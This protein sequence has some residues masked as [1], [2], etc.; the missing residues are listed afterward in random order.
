MTS[1]CS[2][3]TAST[4]A[5]AGGGVFTI[6][7]H[8]PPPPQYCS[9]SCNDLS[10][11]QHALEHS[12]AAQQGLT[13][14][15]SIQH[16]NPALPQAPHGPPADQ[17]TLPRS[18][19]LQHCLQRSASVERSIPRPIVRQHSGLS[20]SPPPIT[21][22]HGTPVTFALHHPARGH[23]GVIYSSSVEANLNEQGMHASHGSSATAAHPASIHYVQPHPG[24]AGDVPM[25]I[26]S[27]HGAPMQG[28]NT[29]QVHMSLGLAPSHLLGVSPAAHARMGTNTMT[30]SGGA[31]GVGEPPITHSSPKSRAKHVTWSGGQ[32]HGEESAV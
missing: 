20:R 21:T 31:E 16:M 29:G 22:H 14:S 1:E 2:T 26:T 6:P 24:L 32:A 8:I 12:A 11:T 19:P 5:S 4:P 15:T 23:L 27:S 18:S 28:A 17:H 30:K 13:R 7:A 25:V 3:G 10:P 9:A